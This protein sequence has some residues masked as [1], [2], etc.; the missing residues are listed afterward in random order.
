MTKYQCPECSYIYDPIIGDDFEGYPSGTKFQDLPE[1]LSS[2]NLIRGDIRD[3]NIVALA[4][5]DVEVIVHLA[6]ETG[7]GQ[8]MYE[9]EKYE[10]TNVIGTLNIIEY[11]LQNKTRVKKIVF[12]SS[13]YAISEQGGIY[14]TSKL[15]SEMIIERL[16]KKF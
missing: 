15:S 8:S 3:K 5:S 14:S 2:I 9:I 6:A 13:I 12:A 4:I 11:L 7:T 1:D 16:C 10:A